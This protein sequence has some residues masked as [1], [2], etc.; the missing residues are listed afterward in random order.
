MAV[1]TDSS[2][3]PRGNMVPRRRFGLF[4]TALTCA[5]MLASAAATCHAQQTLAIR[6]ARVIPIVGDEIAEG[7]VLIVDGR[8]AD[9]GK[10]IEIPVEAK[11]IDAT[12]KV[13][14]PGMINV[15]SAAGMSQSNEQNPIVPFLSVVDSIDPIRDFFEE[16]RRN[17]VT[18][19][20]VVPGNS[21]M[22]GG[23]AAIVK[24]AGQYVDDMIVKRDSALK[25]SLSPVSGSSR[26][27]H[28]ARLRKEL[29][30]A[31]RSIEQADEKAEDAEESEKDED[32]DDESEDEDADEDKADA[33]NDESAAEAPRSAQQ[34]TADETQKAYRKL[35]SGTMPAVIYCPT[36][37][38][39]HQAVRLIEEF[40][41]KAMLVLGRDCYEAAAT[42]ASH[43]LPVALDST[44][45]YWRTDPQTRQDERIVLPKIFTDAGVDYVFQTSD[46]GT[47]LGTHYHWYQAATAVKYGMPRAA[48]LQ[49][50]TL[51]AARFLGIDDV[52]GSIEK[53]KDADLVILTGDPLNVGTWVETTIVNGAVVYEKSQDARLQRLFNPEEDTE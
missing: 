26:M 42:V 29:T 49:K 40:E 6:G 34:T 7:T 13:V 37:M 12:G 5:A 52:V 39:V 47:S 28:I 25:I 53:G 38:D 9:V 23:R 8:I 24:T 19:A 44:L 18:T 31:K 50:L 15:H 2:H 3:I 10:D 30:R 35:L 32:S 27:S 36:A 1:S 20:A 43:K 41:L 21:T 14:M 16:S 51:D 45:V 22:I 33:G 11:V 4:R 17:G 48:A 46:S